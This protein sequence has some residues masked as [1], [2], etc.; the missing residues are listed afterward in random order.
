VERLKSLRLDVP[1]VTLLAYELKKRGFKL[2]DGILT[3]EELV[4][5]LKI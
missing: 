4:D 3:T 2:P 1:Q 5:A